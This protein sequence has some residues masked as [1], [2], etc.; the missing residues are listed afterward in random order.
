LKEAN[1]TSYWISLLKDTHFISVEVYLSLIADSQEL[2][3]MLVS[4]I[5]TLKEK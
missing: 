4:S 3:R 2:I 1:E 5:K